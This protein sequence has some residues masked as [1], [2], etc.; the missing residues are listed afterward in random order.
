MPTPALPAADR[1]APRVDAADVRRDLVHRLCAHPVLK[2][3][4]MTL[5]MTGFFVAYFYLLRHP[6]FPVTEMPRIA[7]DHWIPFTPQAL[8]VYFTL[9]VYVALTPALLATR[10]ELLGFAGWIGALCAFGLGIFWAFPTAVPAPL[11]EPG[12]YPGFS[13]LH[14]VDAAGNA[15]PSLHVAA[16]VFSA[17]WLHRVLHQMQVGPA[18]RVANAL[19]A[20]AIVWSTV[21]VRQHVVLDVLGGLV[22]GALFAIPALR[23]QG[24][25]TRAAGEYDAGARV[26]AMDSRAP[27]AEGSRE[28]A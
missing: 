3:V 26:A 18:W 1:P 15:C 12:T 20:I 21:A 11:I 9:W 7:L 22:L 14:G 24:R 16:A 2:G 4:G 6:V 19:W 13:V 23:W 25:L 28:N 8:W 27:G 17:A 5:G 10:R